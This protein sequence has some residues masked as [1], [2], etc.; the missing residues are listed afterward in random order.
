MLFLDSPHY[1]WQKKETLQHKQ[2]LHEN[3]FFGNKKSGN[4]DKVK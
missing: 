1:K 2:K 3:E 4:F